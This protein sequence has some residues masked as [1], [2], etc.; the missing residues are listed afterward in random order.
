MDEFVVYIL[1]SKTYDLF[2]KGSTSN[3]IQRFRSHNEL[4]NKGYTSKFRPWEVVHV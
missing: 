3:L 1:Y 2:Y 4:A